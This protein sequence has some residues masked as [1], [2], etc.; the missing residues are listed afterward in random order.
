MKAKMVNVR[1]D[2]TVKETSEE[3]FS[4][5]GITM[6]D[7]VNI[8]LRQAV[9]HG[10]FPFAVRIPNHETISAISE[11]ERLLRDPTTKR[12]KSLDELRETLGA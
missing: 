3:I 12:Y 7:A 10:G 9:Y 1:V 8:F 5:I 4:A 11:G 6:S 2:S